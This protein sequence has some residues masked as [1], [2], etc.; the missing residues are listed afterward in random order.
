MGFK[1]RVGT[2]QKLSF[3]WYMSGWTIWMIIFLFVPSYHGVL[4]VSAHSLWA[5]AFHFWTWVH[6]RSFDLIVQSN[7]QAYIFIDSCNS[8][9]PVEW[10]AAIFREDKKAACL[11]AEEDTGKVAPFKMQAISTWITYT[12]A[13]LHSSNSVQL[14]NTGWA[15]HAFHTL[16]PSQKL[17]FGWVHAPAT[18]T[19]KTWLYHPVNLNGVFIGCVSWADSVATG[20]GWKSWNLE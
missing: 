7:T 12:E 9:L 16:R 15:Q 3:I 19:W 18:Q 13:L 14:W 11:H 2:F 5:F 1:N 17:K 8:E 6:A 20:T 10:E 4:L